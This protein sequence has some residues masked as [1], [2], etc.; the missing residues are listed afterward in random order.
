MNYDQRYLFPSLNVYGASIRGDVL[1]GIGWMEIAYYYSLDDK[2][3]DDPFIQNSQFRLLVGYE[4]E[5]A[6][7][8]TVEFQY[9]LEETLNYNNYIKSLLKTAS[10]NEFHKDRHLLTLRLTKLL[11]QQ[12]LKLGIFVYYSPSDNDGY[13][14]PNI[15]YKVSDSLMLETGANLFWGEDPYTFF[16][17]FEKN[18]NIYFAIRY[19]FIVE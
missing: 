8:F 7:D 19:N 6:K 11:M 16:G 3:G 12:N 4:Q 10:Y 13:I 2:D 15:N 17:Q 1:K 5:V 18:S 9:Y 14:R